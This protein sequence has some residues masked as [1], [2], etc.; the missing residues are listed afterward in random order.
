MFHN[1]RTFLLNIF[2]VLPH[3]LKHAPG[4]RNAIRH[5]F[6]VTCLHV[7][8]TTIA[9]P[10]YANAKMEGYLFHICYSLTKNVEEFYH[11]CNRLFHDSD[12]ID[13]VI[14][15][16]LIICLQLPIKVPLYIQ[17]T[18]I[19]LALYFVT[20]RDANSQHKIINMIQITIT[21]SVHKD[22]SQT[23]KAEG[24]IPTRLP[25][26]QIAAISWVSPGPLLP[27][28]SRLSIGVLITTLRCDN[29][30]E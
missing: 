3:S 6:A 25:S 7:L 2:D 23:A 30:L 1:P 20:S 24:I 27:Q 4:P 18:I 21:F 9:L 26:L 19:H 16:F 8:M 22:L 17:H 12:K 14:F 10:H 13:L 28:T 29:S 11:H 5:T 15:S